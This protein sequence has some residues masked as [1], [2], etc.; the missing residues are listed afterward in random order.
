MLN[1]IGLVI[2]TIVT[3]VL[4]VLAFLEASNGIIMLFPVMLTVLLGITLE[5]YDELCVC[6][7]VKQE[8]RY[9]KK[10][11]IYNVAFLIGGAFVTHILSI[12]LELGP[13][14]A[15]AITGLIVAIFSKEYS[16]PAYC[17]A[18]VGMVSQE[19]SRGYFFLLVASVIASVIYIL[20]FCVFNG[21]G[22]KL[23][24]IAF[25]GCLLASFMFSRDLLSDPIPQTDK[26]LLIS[27]YSVAAAVITYV[28][29]IRF[30]KGAVMASSIVGLIS[31]ILLPVIHPQTGSTL[32]VVAICA[33][34]AGM[35]SKE[36]L[37]NE[38][39]VAL[40]GFFS[41]VVYI[42]SSPHLGGAGGKLGTIAF[43]STLAVTGLYTGFVKL[44]NYRSVK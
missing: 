42:L 6:C 34:F 24:T 28:I 25:T 15:A 13:V 33:S 16:V 18:F 5:Y 20:S 26:A 29:S 40:A 19:V 22:G 37:P 8:N 10:E 17:G 3:A 2:L 31:G 21:F 4:F 36:R 38:Y 27:F 39:L 14:L 41:A 11:N 30:E 43:G 44:K 7:T 12:N 23:G 9:L 35:S 32:A 1:L